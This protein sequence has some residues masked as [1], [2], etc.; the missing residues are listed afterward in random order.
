VSITW[1]T[2]D[3]HLGHRKVAQ[4]R[5]F[6]DTKAHDDYTIDSLASHVRNK[7]HSLWVLGDV[8]FGGRGNIARLHEVPG[9]KK[10]VM[11]NHD[12]YPT[13]AYLDVFNKVLGCAELAGLLL[14]H[15]PVAEQQFWRYPAN[16]HGHLHNN[17]IPDL[18]YINVSLEQT[19]LKPVTL[20]Q[21]K[22]SKP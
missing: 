22:E 17:V 15:I 7:H 6:D 10:L 19:G 18:R 20:E 13:L 14:T 3:L 11:G 9:T 5:G 4:M 1:V 8:A 2:S 16:V 21:L 12:R